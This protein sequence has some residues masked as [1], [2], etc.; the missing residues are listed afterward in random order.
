MYGIRAAISPILPKVR[1]LCS[2]HTRLDPM[3]IAT[4]E[5]LAYSPNQKP[6]G[7]R[8]IEIDLKVKAR[9]WKVRHLPYDIKASRVG[10][11]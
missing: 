11:G 3:S 9:I 4:C 5:V 8:R 7:C 2:S 1:S 6:R 10:G